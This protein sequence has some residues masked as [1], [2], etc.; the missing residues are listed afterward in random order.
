MTDQKGFVLCAKSNKES[1]RH[2]ILEPHKDS[3]IGERVNIE[4]GADLS[5]AKPKPPKISKDDI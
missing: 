4:N 2:E 3:V 1:D 5:L